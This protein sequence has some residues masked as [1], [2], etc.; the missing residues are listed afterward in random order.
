MLPKAGRLASPHD[1]RLRQLLR[2]ID[3]DI[4]F[5]LAGQDLFDALLGVLL[6]LRDMLAHV[7]HRAQVRGVEVL[8]LRPHAR[9]EP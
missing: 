8:H 6:D 5:L 4:D 2:L 3:E 9:G 7:R 1:R